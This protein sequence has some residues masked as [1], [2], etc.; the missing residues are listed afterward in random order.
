MFSSDEMVQEVV[1]E[2]IKMQ[3][4]GLKLLDKSVKTNSNDGLCRERH[5][6][7]GKIADYFEEKETTRDRNGN[8]VFTGNIIKDYFILFNNGEPKSQNGSRNGLWLREEYFDF[9][10]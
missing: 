10:N 5:H 3:D 7:D 2:T 4:R 8:V 1:Q 6:M 9:V